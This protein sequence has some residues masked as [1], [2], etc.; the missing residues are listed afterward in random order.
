M[1]EFRRAAFSLPVKDVS[2]AIEGANNYYLLRVAQRKEPSVPPMENLRGD[3]ERRVKEAKALELANK[4]AAALLD[5]L[6][7]E[8]DLQK[9]AAANALQIGETGPF[10]RGDVEIPKVGALEGVRPAEIA[11]SRYHPVADRL[12]AQKNN[13]YLFVFKESQG[14]DMAR[15]EKEKAGLLGQA[16]Q[17]K[18]QAALKK[19]IDSLKAKGRVE[20]EP[21]A[22]EES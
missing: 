11:I 15:F 8:K 16:L 6:K 3:I 14:A 9:F 17:G 22:L 2:T 12:Y 10:L 18:K 4:K 21:R 5:Q 20:V 19:Y 1:E 7:K 13:I